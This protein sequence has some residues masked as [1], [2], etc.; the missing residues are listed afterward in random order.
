VT[1]WAV[2][3]GGIDAYIAA[4]TRQAAVQDKKVC[5]QL[6][7]ERQEEHDVV[8]AASVVEWPFSAEAHAAQLATAQAK[9]VSRA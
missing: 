7:S 3:V 4:P 2:Y 5:D 1:L 9:G 6:D 8:L